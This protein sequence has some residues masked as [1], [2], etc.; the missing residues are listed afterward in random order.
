MNICYF[1]TGKIVLRVET[2][3]PLDV[4]EPY[5]LFLC[6]EE[7][8]NVNVIFR[9]ADVTDTTGK[10]L[11][12]ETDSVDVF[13]DDT[14]Y[15]FF[16]HATGDRQYYAVRKVKKDNLSHHEIF[17]PR[18]YEGKIW[19]RLVF[20]L[21]NFDDIAALMN[22]SVFHASFIEYDGSAILFTAPC[23]TGK[24]TQADLWEKHQGAETINGDKVLIYKDND[25]FFAAGLPF[26]GSS[27]ICKNRIL[28]IKAI[29]R[30]SQAKENTLTRLTGIGAYK[31]V[32]EGCYHSKWNAD[33]N[34]ITSDV[35]V[36]FASNVPVYHLACL[37]DKDATEVLKNELFE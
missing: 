26:S 20:T 16:Y 18:K 12:T 36:S 25:R 33:F 15:Y 35:A 3:E 23:G 14:C 30:L 29:V 10:S 37:P 31:A 2:P 22:A 5:S 21:L 6:G 19:T 34:K 28:A 4:N 8:H 27:D 7:E 9:Y 24:S 11:L 13:A 1:K 17:I 32:F